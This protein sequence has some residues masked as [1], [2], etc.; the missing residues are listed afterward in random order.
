M[1]E[2]GKAVSSA[3]NRSISVQESAIG[4]T[5][6]SGD[7]NQITIIQYQTDR[8]E[9]P[10]VHAESPSTRS[11]GTNP[12]KGLLAFQETDGDRYFGRK[13][14]IEILWEKLRSLYE[15]ESSL[16]LLPV[17]G[18]SGSGKSSLVRA[19]LIPEL[20]RRPLPGQD[21]AQVAALVPRVHPLT[22]LSAVLARAVTRDIAPAAKTREFQEELRRANKDGE[23][24]G[25][26]RIA[27][28]LPGI[29][30]SPLIVLVDQFE[31]A[32]SLCE[33]EEERNAFI[34][35]LLYAAADRSRQV[36]VV[37]TL[38]SDFLGQTQQYPQLNRLFSSQGFLVPAMN[39][40]NLRA[41]IAEPAEQAGYT[42]D[43][44]TIRLLTEQTKGREGALP[45]L[46][47]TLSKIW[48]GLEAAVSVAPATTLQDIGGV[49]GALAGEARRVYESLTEKQKAI[50]RRL[51]LGMV[52]LG[53]GTR[54]TRRRVELDR[55]RAQQDNE[56][57]F[58]VVL[59]RFS[60]SN[61][62]L[63]T[64]ASNLEEIDTV[65]VTH[66]ALF[67]HWQEL[68]NWIDES[69]AD[70]RFQRR[71]DEAAVHWDKQGRPDGLLWRPPDLDLAEDYYN[72]RPIDWT[73]LQIDFLSSST[74]SYRIAKT[75]ETRNKYTFVALSLGL[76]VLAVFTQQ[77]FA[78]RQFQEHFSK[79]LIGGSV[80][81][82]LTYVLPKALQMANRQANGDPE[83]AI[84]NYKSILTATENFIETD[85]VEKIQL[86][87]EQ[88]EE[89]ENIQKEVEDG[90]ADVI[91]RYYISDLEVELKNYR[92]GELK[93]NVQVT[94]FENQYT[95]GALKVTYRLLMRKPGLGAD[96]NDDGYLDTNEA[97]YLP[98]ETLKEIE[99]LWR[100]ITD[101]RCGFYS[102]NQDYYSAKKCQELLYNTLTERVFPRPIDNAMSRIKYCGIEEL[103]NENK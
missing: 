4:S 86:E 44:A 93:N 9:A 39:E 65:E 54:D 92:F 20:A 17:Y 28:L 11:L 30:T 103:A 58:R 88:I 101:N 23:Y 75:R 79:V 96:L 95:E 90:L 70:I 94:D 66:E 61:L 89:I 59:K 47:F 71:L 22:S 15:S 57:D 27:S 21:K 77:Q 51:F 29:T 63:I 1:P 10:V 73:P 3:N 34:T 42:L 53:E 26:H 25:L 5:L 97:N 48:E 46:Q 50:A 37:V 33:E 18:P 13:A 84:E 36:L 82:K 81:P 100:Q 52:Q 38:R 41:A 85:S 102:L 16:R 2:D 43:E 14:E 98:C 45:L 55:L 31:E 12:Y 68:K 6:V 72:R 64:L 19:G 80:D 87:D 99:L 76:T 35:N 24:D 8:K 49:G 78:T 40:D 74:Q 62:R 32:Y 69:R 91:R 67:E 83:A 7:G 56:A 60:A